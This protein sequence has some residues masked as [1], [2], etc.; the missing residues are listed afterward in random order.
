M[1][2]VLCVWL[3]NWPVQR[4]FIARPELEQRALV[5]HARDPRRGERVVYCSEAAWQCGVRPGMAL[6]EAAALGGGKEALRHKGNKA[7]FD[8]FQT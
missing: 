4:I 2:R 1:K 7:V 6:A 8:D 3:P 5:L